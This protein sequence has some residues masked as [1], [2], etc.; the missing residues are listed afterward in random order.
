MFYHAVFSVNGEIP[1]EYGVLAYLA[2]PLPTALMANTPRR[3]PCPVPPRVAHHTLADEKSPL[4]ND[5]ASAKVPIMQTTQ[6]K[7]GGVKARA[8]QLVRNL[9]AAASWDDLMYR[10]YVRQKIEAGL[11]DIAAGR[12]HAHASVRKEFGLS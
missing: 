8:I 3:A 9:P 6:K 1:D 11:S 2:L 12:V 4:A 10:I 7:S 5:N